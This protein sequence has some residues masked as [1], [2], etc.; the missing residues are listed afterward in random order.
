MP[1]LKTHR[2]AAKR[3]KR[4]GTGKFLRRRAYKGHLLTGKKKKVKRR[5]RR[6]AVVA[7]SDSQR[8]EKLLGSGL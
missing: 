2:G 7:P 6:A 3:F 5:L 4:T 1:K 8:L